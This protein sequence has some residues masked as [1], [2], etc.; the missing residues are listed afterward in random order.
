MYS[1][2]AEGHPQGERAESPE[3]CCNDEEYFMRPSRGE[4]VEN[5]RR[6]GRLLVAAR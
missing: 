4:G 5:V 6:A 1:V 3:D 2:D